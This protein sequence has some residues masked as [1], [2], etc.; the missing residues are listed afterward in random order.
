VF[1]VF[2][3]IKEAFISTPIIQ[4]SDWMLSFEMISDAND[5]GVGAALG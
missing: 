3:G 4:P 2:E 5:F 1:K